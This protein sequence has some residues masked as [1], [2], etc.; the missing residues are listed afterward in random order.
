M[1]G[2]IRELD[3]TWGNSC[4][5]YQAFH[6][7]SFEFTGESSTEKQAITM[8]NKRGINISGR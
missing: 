3:K 1:T 6:L 8:G 4:L 7:I 5:C 2:Q